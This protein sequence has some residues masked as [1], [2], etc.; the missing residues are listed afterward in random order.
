MFEFPRV[1]CMFLLFSIPGGVALFFLRLSLAFSWALLVWLDDRILACSLLTLFACIAPC[2]TAFFGFDPDLACLNKACLILNKYCW[3]TL[4]LTWVHLS[5]FCCCSYFCCMR[6]TKETS[7]LLQILSPSTP[8]RGIALSI[9]SA[10]SLMLKKNIF[11]RQTHF[12][13]FVQSNFV[14]S[15]IFHYNLSLLLWLFNIWGENATYGSSSA[16][17]ERLGVKAALCFTAICRY[18]FLFTISFLTSLLSTFL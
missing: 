2:C 7:V 10:S 4:P 14:L 18:L 15:P 11:V 12:E 17:W 1:S 5:H 6:I 8:H 13:C 16:K 3:T 9:F